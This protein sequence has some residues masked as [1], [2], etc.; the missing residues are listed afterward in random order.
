MNKVMALLLTA[1][2]ISKEGS[3]E[4]RPPGEGVSPGGD[5]G[6]DDAA[7]WTDSR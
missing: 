6:G 1:W 5:P 2:C 4:S 7:L 3:A